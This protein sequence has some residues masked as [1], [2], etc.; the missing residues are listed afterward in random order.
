M[1]PVIAIAI[2]AI[3]IGPVIPITIAAITAIEAMAQIPP[4]ESA[5][6]IAPIMSVPVMSVSVMS[7]SVMSVPPIPYILRFDRC[8][9]WQS[10][11]PC[12]I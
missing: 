9:I 6:S 2:T 4:Q 8:N 11:G 10:T 5:V 3:S 12:Q 1:R 7:A